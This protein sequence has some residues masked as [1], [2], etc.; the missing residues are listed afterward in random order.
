METTW[1]TF[2]EKSIDD[3]HSNHVTGLKE[4]EKKKNL[5]QQHQLSVQWHNI[6]TDWLA[7]MEENMQ[8]CPS[9]IQRIQQVQQRSVAQLRS[10][11]VGPAISLFPY[12]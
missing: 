3:V 8:D 2:K 9:Q 5:N 11:V 12:S 7:I 4:Y 6:L 1:N 10:A